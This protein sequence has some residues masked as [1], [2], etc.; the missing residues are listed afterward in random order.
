MSLSEIIARAKQ[1]QARESAASAQTQQFTQFPL[2]QETQVEQKQQFHQQTLVENQ[3]QQRAMASSVPQCGQ[4]C[5]HGFCLDQR[6]FAA[7]QNPI[8]FA[9]LQG[10]DQHQSTS[11]D[12][13]VP[14]D[15]APK[16][17][18]QDVLVDGDF[19]KTLTQLAQ[20]RRERSNRVDNGDQQDLYRRQIRQLADYLQQECNAA[21]PQ[22]VR[23]ALGLSVSNSY[24]Q[25]SNSTAETEVA[26]CDIE[27]LRALLSAP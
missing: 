3:Q 1:A 23:D 16:I 20:L 21:S 10:G 17:A 25:W 6:Q 7:F 13:N 9:P 15:C 14:E 8:S 11:Q 22:S 26:F 5:E 24:A 4:C 18:A 12:V 2:R 19:K 27:K